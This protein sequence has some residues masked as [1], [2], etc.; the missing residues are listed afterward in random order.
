[1]DTL[2][3]I[4]YISMSSIPTNFKIWPC[5]ALA[6]KFKKSQGLQNEYFILTIC[7]YLTFKT[8]KN[9]EIPNFKKLKKF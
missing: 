6:A 8:S 1:M 3:P 7:K 4:S 2:L 9:T 5:G